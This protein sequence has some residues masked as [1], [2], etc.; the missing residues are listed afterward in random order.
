MPKCKIKSPRNPKLIDG[1][2]FYTT[3]CYRK[4]KAIHNLL[5]TDY[6]TNRL[7]NTTC[8]ICLKQIKAMEDLLGT[9]KKRRPRKTD[10]ITKVIDLTKPITKVNGEYQNVYER[11]D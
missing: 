5:E 6:Y 11:E 10:V 2:R 1:Y 7:S 3:Y 4:V 9:K 8:P